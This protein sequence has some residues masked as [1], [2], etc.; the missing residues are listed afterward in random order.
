MLRDPQRDADLAR[1]GMIV[2]PFLDPDEL[3]RLTERLVPL[4]PE[5]EDPFFAA[6]RPSDTHDVRRR[7]C[8]TVM[9]ALG[10]RAS[11]LVVGHRLFFAGVF[12]K[13]PVPESRL[14]LHQDWTFVDESRWRSGNFWVP[15]VDS[16][17]ENGR[18]HAVMG[19]HRLAPTYRGAPLWP[20]ATDR[21]EDL[22]MEQYL[23]H[24]DVAAGDAVL[25]DH[26][27]VHGSGANRSGRSRV[28]AVL[29]IA[30]V[31]APLVH[32]WLGPDGRQLR[33]TVA[34]EF[35]LTYDIGD[36]PSGPHVLDC[37]EVEHDISGF[38][39]DD[40]APLVPT[41]SCATIG[42]RRGPAPPRRWGR[43]HRAR[44]RT[45]QRA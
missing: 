1:D 11:S 22:L 39:P 42:T 5:V 20:Y 28:T 45:P 29:G 3:A 23:T 33:F 24:V 8:D 36:P 12:V 7:L 30:P 31:D 38:G 34:D 37:E 41:G 32:Y 6:Y 13:H 26:Q 17:E 19:S 16:V 14:Q 15:L 27:V 21:V 4:I 2:M 35:F 18:L 43:W 25:Y 44:V 40:L 10:P 9:E